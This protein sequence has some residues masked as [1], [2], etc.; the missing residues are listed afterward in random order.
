MEKTKKELRLY[1]REWGRKK[2]GSTKKSLSQ[3]TTWKGRR[4]ELIALQIL[5]GSSD[6]N[7]TSLNKPFD[8]L[9][10][11]KKIDVKTCNLYKRKIKRYHY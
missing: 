7:A 5:K 2:R 1:K 4:G 9:W 3:S 6:N 10:N 11:D 8:L